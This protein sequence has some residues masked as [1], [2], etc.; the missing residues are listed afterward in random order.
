MYE[1]LR[2]FINRGGLDELCDYCTDYLNYAQ[3]SF[4][5]NK[6]AGLDATDYAQQATAAAQWLRERADYVREALLATYQATG[7]INGDKEVNIGDVTALTD[8]ILSGIPD[9]TAHQR[10]DVNNDGEIT[11]ADIGQL[12]ELI[13]EE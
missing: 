2:N 9:A 5:S 1:I 4:A 12:L 3:P 13:A 10:A 11:I 7:D 6:A 8:I